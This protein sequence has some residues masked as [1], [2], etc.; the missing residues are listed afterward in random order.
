MKVLRIK[1]VVPEEGT[2]KVAF[3]VGIPKSYLRQGS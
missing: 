1:K 3:A 2:M